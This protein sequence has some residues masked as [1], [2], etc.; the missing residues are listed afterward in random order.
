MDPFRFERRKKENLDFLIFEWKMQ[1]G[2]SARLDRQKL[3]S[4]ADV[5]KSPV[6]VGPAPPIPSRN[7]PRQSSRSEET[8]DVAPKATAP[9]LAIPEKPAHLARKSGAKSPREQVEETKKSPRLPAADTPAAALAAVMLERPANHALKKSGSAKSPRKEEVVEEKKSEERPLP[10]LKEEKPLPVLKEEK[11]LPVLRKSGADEVK[12]EKPLPVPKEERPLPVLKEEKPLPVLRKSGA[13]EVKEEKPLPVPKEERP[14]PVLKEEKPLPVL[15]KSGADEVK[16]EKPLPVP[17]EERPLPVL[18]E[19]KP[20]P[21]LR[22]S[23]ADE[24]KEEKPLPVPKEERPLPVL[25]K[26]AGDEKKVPPLDVSVERPIVMEKP[27]HLKKKSP[28]VVAEEERQPCLVFDLVCVECGYENGAASSETG[29]CYSCSSPLQTSVPDVVI[30][31]PASLRCANKTCG[32]LNFL[33]AQRCSRCGRSFSETDSFIQEDIFN[34]LKEALGVMSD[35]DDD[36]AAVLGEAAANQ[37]SDEGEDVLLSILP[38]EEAAPPPPRTRK[39]T[40]MTKFSEQLRQ[41][42]EASAS[43]DGSN[44]DAVVSDEDVRLFV[45][46]VSSDRWEASGKSSDGVERFLMYDDA[47]LCRFKS[48]TVLAR[49]SLSEAEEMLW[50]LANM[51]RFDAQ[52]YESKVVD[53]ISSNCVVGQLTVEVAG[54]GRVDLLC[55][56]VRGKLA[57]GD[58]Y[59]LMRSLNQGHAY[60]VVLASGLVEMRVHGFLLSELPDRGG[61]RCAHVSCIQY[62]DSVV[63]ASASP[64]WNWNVLPKVVW[65]VNFLS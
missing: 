58:R 32:F 17:K 60:S 52:I 46:E 8:K 53:Q 16:E 36:L 37:N 12:E 4:S 40:L 57:N 10:V 24:V 19:E 49:F 43:D 51:P 6:G 3:V 26:S 33:D 15:R 63:P 38:P 31:V 29:V 20:L 61:T 59:I 55:G 11:P 21:V 54:V 48:E 22:K 18:K 39:Q 28:R 23:G 64:K 47:G 56:R 50:P 62:D 44:K 41:S 13:D 9:D 34:G 35:E 14:L 2:P 42:T 1:E 5:A 27:A 25:R 65:S 7:Y 30:Q 45:A